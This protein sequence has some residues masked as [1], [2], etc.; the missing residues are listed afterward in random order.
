[1]QCPK[2]LA[3][4]P[5]TA[6]YCGGC[7]AP[8]SGP[9]PPADSLTKTLEI[10]APGLAR[11]SVVAKKYR[12]VEEIGRGGMGIVYKAEDVKLTRI[13]ALKFLPPQWTADP[14]ARERFIQEARAASAL[15]HP[16][17]CNIHEIEETDDGRMYIAMAYYEGESLRDKIKRGPLKKEEALDLIVQ[18]VRGM[19][20]AHQTGIVHRDL[21]PANILVTQE[22][23]AKIVDFGLAK[24]AGQV[25]LTREGTTVGTLAY[26]SP[27]QATGKALDERTDIWS[28]GVVLY[29]MLS[30]SLPFK[31][32]YEQSVIHAILSHDPEPLT[33]VRKDVPR[34]IDN[35]LAK[36][37]E[38]RPAG[39]YQ[40][41]A[42]FLADLEAVAEGLRPLKAKTRLLQGRIFSLRKSHVY[43]GI[44]GL[45]VLVAL[46]IIGPFRTHAQAYDSIAWLPLENLSGDPEQDS[47]AESIHDELLTNLAGLSGL[48][49]VIARSTVMSYKGSNVP[50]QQIA[51]A[52]DVNCLIT[53]A[54]RLAG[55]RVRVTVQVIDPG[56]GAQ[57]WA[58]SYERGVRDITTLE[59]E[60]VAEIAR[61][62]GLPLTSGERSRLASAR[63]VNPEAYAAYTKGRFYL[64]KPTPGEY[65]KGLAYM[66]E[67]IDKDPTSPLPYAALAL[68]LC[69]IGHGTNPPPDAFVKAKAAA[70]KAEELGGTLAET[71]AALG[72]IKLF[73]EWDWAGAEKDL[74]QAIA[75]NPSLPEAQ[76]MYSWYLLL[77]GRKDEAIEAMKRAIDVD[78]LTPLWDSDLAWQY[79]TMGRNEE[80]IE[81]ARKALEL[82]PDFD[83]ALC[84]LGFLYSEKGKFA[85]AIAT[86]QKLATISRPWR[87]ALVR[88]L[89][90]AG[91]RDEAKTLLSEYLGQGQARGRWAGWF[92]G[93][94]Y[95]A[96]GDKDEAFRWLTAAVDERMTFI[97][98]M[99]QNPA[100]APLRVDPRFQGLVRRMDLPELR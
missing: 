6:R 56:T 7:A 8:L 38:K 15:D 85:E 2:C 16:N 68:G 87:W 10:A 44:G 93:E 66:Q 4:N 19:A 14:D 29:E 18:A 100:Y 60:I 47:L 5:E 32:D 61:E 67:A 97:P 84:W 45:A 52:L 65:E 20:K 96:L 58:R 72:Q 49:K 94:I 27:E 90:Q 83:Q 48:K 75:L 78:P 39:R 55:D 40:S 37:L 89:A 77:T 92:L 1:M 53:G 73:E 12:I 43:A 31:G 11:G 21:K 22:G 74:R 76:R 50:P 86:H 71:V 35:V 17:I 28:L 13:V 63:P 26:M 81:A 54:M 95:A 79:W 41:M 3:D 46:F 24:L 64:N 23:V 34:E 82:D 99:R 33:G 51:R 36:A 80:A 9:G 91:R 62:V 25:R 69:L 70:L 57:V 88:T 98:W 30:G 59:N 42:E